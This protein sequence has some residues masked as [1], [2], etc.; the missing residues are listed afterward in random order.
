MDNRQTLY[1][2][3]HAD[4]VVINASISIYRNRANAYILTVTDGAHPA[5][6]PRD[7]GGITLSSHEAYVQQRL[8][9]DKAAMRVLGINTD[10]RYTNSQIPDKQ[11]YLNIK[12]IVEI[13]ATLVKRERIRRIMTHSFPGE[14]HASHPDHEIVSVCSHIV[15]NEYGIDVLEYAGFKSNSTNKQIGTIFPEEDQMETV[16]CDFSRE[17]ATLRDELMQ[18]YITQGFIIGKY[19]TTREMFGR[20]A[21]DP[22]TIPDT[23][24]VYGGADYQPTPQDIR[25][26]IADFL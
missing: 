19:R 21:Q 9:E 2:G 25:K 7:L 3:A 8:K 1:I 16:R 17:E 5:T 12:R 6:Y 14:S 15:G 11:T 22:K 10:K 4:D 23:T 18:I 26:A 20:V 13:I 24:D